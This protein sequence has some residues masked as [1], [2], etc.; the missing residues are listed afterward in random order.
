MFAVLEALLHGAIA[1]AIVGTFT[2]HTTLFASVH[3][4]LRALAVLALLSFAIAPLWVFYD[5]R[6][7]DDSFVWVHAVMLPLV[8]LFGLAAY[9]H[10]RSQ[11]SVE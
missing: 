5:V 3:P 8:N 1:V 7:A 4:A 2:G 10:H 9:L 6:R 11:R